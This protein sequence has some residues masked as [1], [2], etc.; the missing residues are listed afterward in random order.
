[1]SLLHVFYHMYIGGE[2]SKPTEPH[3]RRLTT[4]DGALCFIGRRGTRA[5]LQISGVSGSRIPDMYKGTL[6]VLHY[7]EGITQKLR[8]PLEEKYLRIEPRRAVRRRL[9][10]LVES[11]SRT[12]TVN[13][14]SRYFSVKEQY[15]HDFGLGDQPCW[16]EA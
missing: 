3:P 9:T 6:T 1:M 15:T 7:S 13:Q 10:G 14:E 5:G 12:L 2:E 11:L 16:M 4:P 8:W